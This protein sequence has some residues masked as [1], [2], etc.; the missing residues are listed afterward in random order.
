[1]ANKTE[2]SNFSYNIKLVIVVPLHFMYHM[3]DRDNLVYGQSLQPGLAEE[4]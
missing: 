2:P 4:E 1:M 3:S